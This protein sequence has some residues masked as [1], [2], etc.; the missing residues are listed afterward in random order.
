MK[1]D[2]ELLEKRRQYV[3]KY[4]LDNK[5]KQLKV[6]TS[7]LS[8][9]LFLTERTIYEIMTKCPEIKSFKKK[10]E[11]I[12]TVKR[13]TLFS[14]MRKVI[15]N[16][17]DSTIFEKNYLIDKVYEETLTNYSIKS[18]ECLTNYI[19]KSGYVKTMSR[20]RYQKIKN[21]PLDLTSSKM[22][23]DAYPPRK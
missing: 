9:Q 19:R 11:K 20:E 17:D 3:S 2:N 22:I 16:I 23:K 7:E 1:R 12:K 21:I 8:E 13:Q 15:N 6:I 14:I 10:V 4:I 5:D 18:I